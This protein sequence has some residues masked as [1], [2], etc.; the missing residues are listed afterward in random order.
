MADL[1]PDQATLEAHLES[2]RFLKG[3]QG[4]RWSILKYQF[5]ELYVRVTGRH[6]GSGKTYTHDFRLECRGFPTTP[7]FVERWTYDVAAPPGQRSLAPTGSPGFTDAMKDWGDGGI[8]RAW[9]R[10]AAIHNDW[11]QKRPDDA[12]HPDRHL[13][14]IMEALYALM[15]EQAFWLAAQEPVPA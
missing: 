9:Q 14:F 10:T 7:P 12:W 13:E 4:G 5:P 1:A 3:V 11:S 6:Y 2:G 15:A 8:Y